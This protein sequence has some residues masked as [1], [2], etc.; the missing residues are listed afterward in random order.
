MCRQTGIT[1]I[2]YRTKVADDTVRLIVKICWRGRVSDVRQNYIRLASDG[3]YQHQG[4]NWGYH[5]IET[6]FW[7][8]NTILCSRRYTP[9]TYCVHDCT[10]LLHVLKLAHWVQDYTNLLHQLNVAHWV[11]NC[12]SLQNLLKLGHWL[13]DCTNPPCRTCCNLY[14]VLICKP[15][16]NFH[17][18]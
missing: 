15:C 16:C 4:I 17:T 13:Q 1:G 7:P 14:T 11:E 3:Y 6:F 12:T 2:L 5:Q 10:N 8:L 9:G 18:D